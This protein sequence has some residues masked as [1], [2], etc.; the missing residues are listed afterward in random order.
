MTEVNYDYTHLTDDE[1][2]N[3]IGATKIPK[4][5]RTSGY[6]SD[7]AESVAQLAEL[8]IQ[9]L[10]NKGLDPDEALEWARKL[11]ESVSQSEFDS[12]VATLLDGGPSIFMNTLNELKTKYPNGAPGVAL[13]RETDPAKI[14][15][16]NGTSW[17]D[18][19][20]YQGIELKDGTISNI[21]I[22]NDAVSKEKVNFIES[23]SNL[24]NLANSYEGKIWTMSDDRSIYLNDNSNVISS[25][26]V[27]LSGSERE[28]SKNKKAGL[29]FLDKNEKVVVG[30][31]IGIGNVDSKITIPQDAASFVIVATKENAV[32]LMVNFGELA[33]PYVDGKDIL[34]KGI[35]VNA[36]EIIG[37]INLSNIETVTSDN[38]YNSNSMTSAKYIN[39]V[40]GSLKDL[41]NNASSDFIDVDGVENITISPFKEDGVINYAFYNYSKKMI[42]SGQITEKN[43][44]HTLGVP[45][46]AFLFRFSGPTGDMTNMIVQSG[47]EITTN[48]QYYKYPKG[49]ALPKTSQT[50][51]DKTVSVN[52][53]EEKIIVTMSDTTYV[54]SKYSIP[55]SDG[56]ITQNVDTWRITDCKVNNNS[57]VNTG[58]WEMAIGIKDL[59]DFHGTLHGYEILN[60]RHMYVDDKKVTS[61][62]FT[63]EKFEIAVGGYLIKQ[64][65]QDEQIAKFTRHYVFRDG[66]LTLTQNVE[67]VQ[68]LQI[69]YG[70]LAMLPIRPQYAQKVIRDNDYIEYDLSE[71]DTTLPT[72]QLTKNI[73]HVKVYGD[74]VGVDITVEYQNNT[75]P[76]HNFINQQADYNKVYFSYATNTTASV[77]DKWQ[78]KS[79][80]EIR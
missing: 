63:G 44:K 50:S 36:K 20:D 12:W 7:F 67:W 37:K 77:G 75:R 57:I 59:P 26:V 72:R 32:G 21:N 71:V 56:G 18:F 31:N 53:N 43:I 5:I 6:V 14:Y 8:L 48:N 46:G 73:N 30:G 17:E 65:T 61:G 40:D 51:N 58:A 60:A 49:L 54:L 34:K 19:G 33:L 78:V 27:Y 70:Y 47:Y 79:K 16:W 80:Y 1:K 13:V 35:K 76:N 45:T 69:E 9:S 28:L 2:L 22:K 24:F 10:M 3:G 25:D 52:V 11:Q 68:S 39:R 29:L 64:G 62:E 42:G 23:T 74:N 4:R 41:S 66:R 38:L 15:V 55:F